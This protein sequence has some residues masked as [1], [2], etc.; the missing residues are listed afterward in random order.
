MKCS[1]CGAE[2]DFITCTSCGGETPREGKY[3]CACGEMLPVEQEKKGEPDEWSQR[4]LCSDGT[5]IGIIGPDGKCKECGK[6]YKGPA[7]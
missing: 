5:C 3:C 6:R 7:E 4:V 1:E 2:L